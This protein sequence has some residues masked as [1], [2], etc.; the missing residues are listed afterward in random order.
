ML[1]PY[2]KFTEAERRTIMRWHLCVT[3][4][5]GAIFIVLLLFA[6]TNHEISQKAASA[7]PFTGGID[8]QRH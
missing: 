4:F 8:V 5:Y 6:V 7:A 3:A 1:R 2:D